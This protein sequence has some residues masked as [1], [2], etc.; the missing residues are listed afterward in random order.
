MLFYIREEMNS[1]FTLF[2]T[3]LTIALKYLLWAI[4]IFTYLVFDIESFVKR[5]DIF[6]I[7]ID[8][9]FHNT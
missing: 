2:I 1:F 5:Y 8:T 3:F 9:I 4:T 6:I 7:Y